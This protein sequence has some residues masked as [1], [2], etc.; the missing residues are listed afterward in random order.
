MALAFPI[1]LTRHNVYESVPGLVDL[2]LPNASRR[3]LV[4]LGAVLLQE[5]ELVVDVALPQPPVVLAVE[6]ENRDGVIAEAAAAA[7]ISRRNLVG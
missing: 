7:A 4:Q 1:A 3:F 6:L 2:Q 5:L